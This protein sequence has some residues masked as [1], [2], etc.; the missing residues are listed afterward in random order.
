MNVSP[1]IIVCLRRPRRRELNESRADPFWEFG[2]FGC[3][4]CHS[5]NLM[6]PK[7]LDELNGVRIAFAQGG[8]LGFRLVHLTPPVQASRMRSCNQLL[9]KPCKMPFRY[10]FAPCLIDNSGT[11]RFPALRTHLRGVNRSTWEGAF[12]SKF[13]SSRSPL[14]PR[15]ATQLC[16]R[17]DADRSMCRSRE[18]CTRY[19]QALPWPPPL[20]D[21]K[22]R[23]IYKKLTGNAAR[24][25]TG[26]SVDRETSSCRS[27]SKKTSCSGPQSRRCS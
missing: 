24:C 13:R 23:A 27:T 4:N 20:I 7:R 16:E 19:D 2:S 12:S 5:R 10:E 11:T 15:I 1:V 18:I 8:P 26:T 6:N 3:T 25:S 14:L 9:W 22:R 17:Y 21:T